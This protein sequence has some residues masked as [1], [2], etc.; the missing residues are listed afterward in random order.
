M[1]DAKLTIAPVRK[2]VQVKASSAHAF[3]VFT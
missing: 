1:T 2:S 3:K